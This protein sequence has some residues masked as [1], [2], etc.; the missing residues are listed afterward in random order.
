MRLKANCSLV[1]VVDS[2][3]G[4]KNVDEVGFEPTTS[5]NGTPESEA[6]E[7]SALPLC[8]PPAGQHVLFKKYERAFPGRKRLQPQ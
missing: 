4:K 6:C 5:C 7:A 3:M 2:Q 8:H 1:A